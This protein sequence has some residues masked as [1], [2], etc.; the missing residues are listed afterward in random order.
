M[1]PPCLRPATKLP[2]LRRAPL[3]AAVVLALCSGVVL[4]AEPAAVTKPAA[5]P[6][7]DL[8]QLVNIEFT[9]AGKKEQKLSEVA[10]AAHILTQDDLRRAGVTSIAEALRLVPGLDVARVDSH[11]WAVS[12]RGFNSVFAN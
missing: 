3:L 9:S 8:E 11:T 12:S 4:G 10:A 7:L 5:L 2:A 1:N 6:D